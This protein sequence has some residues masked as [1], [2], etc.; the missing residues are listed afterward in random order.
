MMCNCD[1]CTAAVQLQD[2]DHCTLSCREYNA[3]LDSNVDI[4]RVLYYRP[5]VYTTRLR[6]YPL[7]DRP[8]LKPAYEGQSRP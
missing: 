8:T 7:T 1:G 4:K 6:Y 5:L 2:N 3:R